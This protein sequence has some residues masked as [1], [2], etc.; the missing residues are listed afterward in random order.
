MHCCQ[1]SLKDFKSRKEIYI[2]RYLVES[3]FFFRG[4]ILLSGSTVIDSSIVKAQ[5]EYTGSTETKLNFQS[6]ID[7]SSSV[8]FCMRLSQPDAVFK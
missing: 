4:G 1:F 7:F 3:F 5:V 2:A 6:D 8:K